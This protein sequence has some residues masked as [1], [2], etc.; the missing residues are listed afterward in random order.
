MTLN[1]AQ[2]TK[3][4]THNIER[5]IADAKQN[6]CLTLARAFQ[7]GEACKYLGL[8]RPFEEAQNIYT[9]HLQKRCNSFM[10]QKTINGVMH[11]QGGFKTFDDAQQ[12]MAF[13][14]GDIE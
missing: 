7:E 8:D 13:F 3:K 1:A 12:A 5:R 9:K 11:D 10:W 4:D 2:K 14:L 6:V